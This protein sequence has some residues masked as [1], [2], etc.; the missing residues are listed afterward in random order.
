MKEKSI[1][2]AIEHIHDSNTGYS[3]AN[4]KEEYY[5]DIS[6]LYEKL[7][8]WK[9]SPWPS[10]SPFA[11]FDCAMAALIRETLN[12]HEFREKEYYDFVINP[13]DE[14]IASRKEF[15]EMFKSLEV[16]KN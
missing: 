11:A 14:L 8:S 12:G 7:R 16:P 9:K 1:L 5:E 4:S 13:S 6:F 2:R 10:D 3:D 15:D